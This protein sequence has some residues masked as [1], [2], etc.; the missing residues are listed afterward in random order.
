MQARL[1]LKSGENACMCTVL[2][3]AGFGYIV[4]TK[5]PFYLFLIE[6]LSRNG[7]GCNL[8]ALAWMKCFLSTA[9]LT[10]ERSWHFLS[11]TKPFVVIRATEWVGWS[12]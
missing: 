5:H 6:S 10:Q 1:G 7:P 9:A 3:C 8:I 12:S 2:I 4:I 11:K